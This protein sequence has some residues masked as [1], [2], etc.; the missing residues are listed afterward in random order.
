MGHNLKSI[1]SNLPAIG[2]EYS[3]ICSSRNLEQQF[4]SQVNYNAGYDTICDCQDPASGTVICDVHDDYYHANL[5]S[6]FSEIFWFNQS[7]GQY[8][9]KWTM[10]YELTTQT[11]FDPDTGDAKSCSVL[12]SSNGGIVECLNCFICKDDSGNTGIAY[13]CGRMTQEGSCDTSLGRAQFNLY[14]SRARKPSGSKQFRH[15]SKRNYTAIIVGVSFGFAAL[16]TILF[17]AFVLRRSLN[18]TQTSNANNIN[19]DNAT[20]AESIAP[21][22]APFAPDHTMLDED[23]SNPMEGAATVIHVEIEQMPVEKAVIT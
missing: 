9:K 21:S 5:A 4:Y 17:L 2:G 8:E 10:S 6:I 15:S 22:E 18:T 12:L 20:V 13:S 14:G 11:I 19:D 3:V 23:F 16:V 7:N 1:H